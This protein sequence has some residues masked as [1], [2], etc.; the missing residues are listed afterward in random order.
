[1]TA[2]GDA[3]KDPFVTPSAMT[4]PFVTLNAMKDP[5]ITVRPV[6]GAA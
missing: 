5:F 2:A 4:D 1:M 3:M 6:G